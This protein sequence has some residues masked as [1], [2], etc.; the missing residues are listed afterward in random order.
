VSNLLAFWSESVCESEV[1]LNKATK[2][3]EVEVY[4]LMWCKD[5]A[6]RAAF[7]SSVWERATYVA[8]NELYYIFGNQLKAQPVVQL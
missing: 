7:E 3:R 8:F 5:Y 4:I 1:L 2:Q 6:G